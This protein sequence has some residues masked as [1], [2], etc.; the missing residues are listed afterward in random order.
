MKR[1]WPK[2]ELSAVSNLEISSGKTRV[3]PLMVGDNG[4]INEVQ[5]QFP[6]QT[7]K[8]YIRWDGKA[9]PVVAALI[10]RLSTP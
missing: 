1:N 5:S 8:F 6:L 2:R 3:L 4:Y 7:N 10:D 9:E